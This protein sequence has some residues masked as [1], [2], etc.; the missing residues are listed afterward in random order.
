MLNE[1][2]LELV[3]LILTCVNVVRK[4]RLLNMYYYD[5]PDI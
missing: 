4:G 1:D 2:A 5:A 3:F